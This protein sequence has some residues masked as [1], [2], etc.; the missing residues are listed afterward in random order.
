M[1]RVKDNEAV[2]VAKNKIANIY[3]TEF[4]NNNAS[5]EELAVEYSRTIETLLHK[6]GELGWISSGGNVLSMHLKML[7]LIFHRRRMNFSA[8][9]SDS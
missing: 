6:G 9:I 4:N 5:F 7:F 3:G 1:P 2:E 8:T